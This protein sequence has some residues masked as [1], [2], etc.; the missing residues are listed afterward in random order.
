MIVILSNLII[1]RDE[2]VI[3][4]GLTVDELVTFEQ[5]IKRNCMSLIIKPVFLN[6]IIDDQFIFI[7]CCKL[8]IFVT[9]RQ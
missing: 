1:R 7:I 9:A 4:S 6:D 3:Y 2:E 8:A 5:S